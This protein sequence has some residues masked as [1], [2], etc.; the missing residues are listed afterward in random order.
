MALYGAIA[1][2]RNTRVIPARCHVST[3]G[4]PLNANASAT[5]GRQTKLKTRQFDE[6]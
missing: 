3:T 6:L 4:K 1:S 2:N 5:A